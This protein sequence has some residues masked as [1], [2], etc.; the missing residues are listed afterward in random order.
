MEEQEAQQDNQFLKGRQIAYVIFDY[1]KTSGI[2]E[3]LLYFNDLLRVQLKNDN[4]QV[5]DTKWDEVLS[6]TGV[7]DGDFCGKQVQK[8]IHYSEDLKNKKTLMALYFAGYAAERRS[9]Q[10]CSTEANISPV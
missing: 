5:F 4:V 8:L 6:M 9:G 10:L 7:P 1:L 3:A 2:G